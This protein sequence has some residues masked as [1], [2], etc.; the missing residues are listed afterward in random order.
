MFFFW[1]RLGVQDLRGGKVSGD[2][3]QG[4]AFRA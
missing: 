3:V 4:L 1:L 2:R